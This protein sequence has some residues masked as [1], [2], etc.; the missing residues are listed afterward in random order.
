LVALGCFL[1]AFAVS[2]F[3][4][5]ALLR[6]PTAR[7]FID[8]P[9]ERSSHEAPKPRIGGVAIVVS[10][11]AALAYLFAVVPQARSFIPLIIGSGLLFL[12]GLID[13]WR[14]LGVKVRFTMQV[15]AALTVV[16]FG[17]TLDHLYIPAVG[18]VELG[19]LSVPMTVFVIVVSI[20]FYNFIDGID[21]LAAGS[22]FIASGFLALIA[23]M[24]GHV[25]LALLYVVA[26]GSAVGFLQF[27]FPPSRLF[28][29]DSGSTFLGFL[30]AYAALAGNR[31]EP[32]LPVFIPMLLL[33]S[34]YLDAGLTLFNRMIKREN[35]F[36]AHHTHYYQRLLSLGL[37]HKQVTLL[38]YLLIILLG[39]SAV[40]YFKAGGFFPIFLSV[41]WFVLFTMAILKIRGLERGDKLFWEKRTLFAIGLDLV[42]ITVAYLGAYFL[43][44]NFRFT[45]PEGVAVIRALPLVLVVRSAVFFKYGLYRSVYKYTSTADIIRIVKAVTMGS[46]IILIAV[47]L[48]YRFVAFPRTLFII[49]FFLLTLL[50]LGSRFSFRLFHELGRE[51]QGAHVRRFG[52]VGAGDYGER[53]ARELRND[54]GRSTSVA[55][56]IDDDP[57]KIGLML[58]G[59]PI[60]GPIDRLPEI[61][62]EQKLDALAI[63]ISKVEPAKMK[64]IMASAKSAGVPVQGGPSGL[65]TESEPTTSLFDRLSHGLRRGALAQVGTSA[66]VFYRGKRVVLTGGGGPI[67]AALAHE[68]VA[69]GASVTVQVDSPR[70][71]ARFG[72]GLRRD[73]FVH[74]G[75]P[76][77]PG[78][79]RSLLDR[80]SPDV[81]FHCLT[82]DIDADSNVDEYLWDAAVSKTASLVT[83]VVGRRREIESARP[84]VGTGLP[85]LIMLTFWDGSEAGGAGEAGFHA[86]GAG[87]AAE[88]VVLNRPVGETALPKAIRFPKVFTEETLQSVYHASSPDA[89][90]AAVRYVVLEP[91]AVTLALDCAA[92]EPGRAI[93]VPRGEIPFSA[94]EAA[95]ILS[96]K[97]SAP[98]I[99]AP[100]TGPRP[101]FPAESIA[102]TTSSGNG[103]RLNS[104][105]YPARNS[106]ARVL[107]PEFQS[108][109]PPT[110]AEWLATAAGALYSI[111]AIGSQAGSRAGN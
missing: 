92:A 7:G 1:I 91:E 25:H 29:G 88:V 12:T 31:L 15:F 104:P 32:E 101:V 77:A 61:C 110:Y 90:D 94:A 65:H 41:C 19:W 46:A 58:H 45:D 37:N 106:L 55:C 78:E 107:T 68:L 86:A 44:M 67:G 51:A 18:V 24:L 47:V 74:M 76:R 2:Y 3:G 16:L 28:M 96:E 4:T 33:S 23:T 54:P 21:G 27:N 14:G 43:R 9:N 22:A 69:R 108:A 10:F 42:L 81:I 38:E 100:P 50:I 34:L 84:A 11:Y 83:A 53:I 30:F 79:W 60:T 39:V 62:A 99:S 5:I 82:L 48:L 98:L 72:S 93:V 95:A 52:I 102:G 56:F 70:E 97:R 64:Q 111:T 85:S 89:S 80:T 6:I 8:I 75:T 35:I 63:G 57:G 20:N 26:A 40:V 66:R 71:S 13:D 87:A 17:V 59:A 73:V 36:Q 49:E 109:S 103:L 105:V